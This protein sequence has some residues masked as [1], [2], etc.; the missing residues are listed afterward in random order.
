MRSW[1]HLL[2]AAA[3]LVGVGGCTGEPD[4]VVRTSGPLAAGFE[5]EPGSGLIGTEFPYDGEGLHVYLRVDGDMQEVLEGYVRQAGELGFPVTAPGW[6]PDGQWCSDDP[7]EWTSSG[8]EATAFELEC[9]ASGGDLDSPPFWSMSLRGLVE[10]DGSGYLRISG[11][12]FSGEPAAPRPAVGDGTV[13]SLTDVEIA[14]TLAVYE[15][16]PIRVVEGSELVFDPLPSTCATGGWVAMLR[17][18]GE[19]LPVLRGYAEQFDAMRAFVPAELVGDD[20]VT[21]STWAPGGGGLG[22]VGVAGDPAYVLIHRCN[23]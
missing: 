8:G 17:V 12:R 20:E 23:D 21:V 3:C 11:G 7:A 2:V 18:V 4:D 22:A 13:A 16:E 10:A 1:R 14:P 9:S 5:L 6:W 19:L 15:D